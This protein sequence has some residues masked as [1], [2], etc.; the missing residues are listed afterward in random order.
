[1]LKYMGTHPLERVEHIDWSRLAYVK[2]GMFLLDPYFVTTQTF[3]ASNLDSCRTFKQSS[4]SKIQKIK[5]GISGIG[6]TVPQKGT[7]IPNSSHDIV[8]CN[9]SFVYEK[10]EDTV[11]WI[12]FR[13]IEFCVQVRGSFSQQKWRKKIHLVLENFH[14][15]T[16]HLSIRELYL[17]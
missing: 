13:F 11:L 10:R 16:L 6:S 9:K 7:K 15:R 4:R 14:K 17:G 2:T 8:H 12:Y 3:Y 5:T 1:M